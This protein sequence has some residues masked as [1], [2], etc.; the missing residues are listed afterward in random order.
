MDVRP[1]QHIQ[2][3][4]SRGV[5]ASPRVPTA[6][7]GPT[8]LQHLKVALL[9]SEA[10]RV[11][12]PWTT[13]SP[14]PSEDVEMALVDST[15]ASRFIPLTTLGRG[16]TMRNAAGASFTQSRNDTDLSTR[17]LRGDPRQY[18]Y[19]I[20]REGRRIQQSVSALLPGSI[21]MGCSQVEKHQISAS[22]RRPTIQDENTP[23][24]TKES[25]EQKSIFCALWKR[26]LRR[27]PIRAGQATA[28][29]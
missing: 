14:R 12:V 27:V 2:V 15:S 11:T 18:R 13:I 16:T 5:D 23:V 17:Q 10:T 1:L 22:L 21:S 29:A 3:P 20:D 24:E 26:E 25:A 6:P 4:R 28:C 19:S 9:G 8:P 7:V